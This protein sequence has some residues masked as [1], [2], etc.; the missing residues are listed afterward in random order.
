MVRNFLIP[1]TDTGESLH[2]T[3]PP[4][5]ISALEGRG[6]EG[7]SAVPPLLPCILR[8]DLT[9]CSSSS[10]V[11]KKSVPSFSPS[12]DVFSDTLLREKRREG[13]EGG[14]NRELSLR[15]WGGVVQKE[16]VLGV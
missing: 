2:D 13:G 8:D 16:D 12:F 14:D 7:K 6:G 5:P 11:R 10:G 15:N 1:R 4:R 9:L 3:K